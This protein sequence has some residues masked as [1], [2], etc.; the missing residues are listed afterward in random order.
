MSST[1]RKLNLDT[2]NVQA[3]I[4]MIMQIPVG[5]VASY[6]QIARLAGIPKNARQ[7]GAVLRALP[8][9]SDVPWFRVVNSK[10]EIAA[11]GHAESEAYQRLKLEAEGVDFDGKGRV[12]MKEYCW[13]A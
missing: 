6:G 11:R 9:R 7:V 1:K 8:R 2:P 12:P 3:I 5:C 13:S 10:G 4:A